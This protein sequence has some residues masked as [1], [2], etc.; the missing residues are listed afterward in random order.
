MVAARTVDTVGSGHICARVQ[1]VVSANHM[2]PADFRPEEKAEARDKQYKRKI[3]PDKPR[4][5]RYRCWSGGTA[6]QGTK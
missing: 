5:V 3:A 2:H 6:H 4:D 1:I